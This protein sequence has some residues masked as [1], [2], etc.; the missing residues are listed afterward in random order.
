MTHTIDISGARIPVNGSALFR[1]KT[2]KF[3]GLNISGFPIFRDDQL[4]MAV[5]QWH[6]TSDEIALM[7]P[8]LQ[9]QIALDSESMME[10]AQ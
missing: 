5:C 3:V 1:A 2:A 10:A 7:P 4:R 8:D 6:C 9:R